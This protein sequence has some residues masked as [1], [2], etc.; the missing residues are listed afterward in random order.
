MEDMLEK[1]RKMLR[2]RPRTITLEIIKEEIDIS[3][4]WLSAFANNKMPNP[5]YNR[6]K[7]LHDFLKGQNDTEITDRN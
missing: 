4:P 2:E 6:I 3:L 7:A 1:T 5:S